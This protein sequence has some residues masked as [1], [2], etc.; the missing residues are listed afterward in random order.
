[1]GTA[2]ESR[3][4]RSSD[5]QATMPHWVDRR[6]I[7]QVLRHTAGSFADRTAIVFQS[8]NWSLTWR[9]F[10]REV[11]EAAKALLACGIG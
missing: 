5:A 2:D 3:P 11:D 9:E 4:T 10:D 8:L 6:T 1:M 7:G